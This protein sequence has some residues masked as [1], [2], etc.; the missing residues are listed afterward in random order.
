MKYFLVS[1]EGLKGRR[2]LRTYYGVESFINRNEIWKRFN[3]N[4]SEIEKIVNEI[5]LQNLIGI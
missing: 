5:L 2:C 4:F 1:H 3:R